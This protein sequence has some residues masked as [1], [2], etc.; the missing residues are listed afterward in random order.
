MKQAEA[1]YDYTASSAKEISF[2]AGDVFDLLNS[3]NPDWWYVRTLTSPPKEGYAPSTYIKPQ[4]ETA[5]PIRRPN[6]Q[7]EQRANN[8]ST[9]P[10]LKTSFEDEHEVE[11]EDEE[12]DD[13]EEHGGAE[14]HEE[15]RK[16]R[17]SR[18]ESG[19]K[20]SKADYDDQTYS[21]K[22][23]MPAEE[24]AYS[25]KYIKIA[26]RKIPMPCTIGFSVIDA[27]HV[28]EQIQMQG[29]NVVGRHVRIALFDKQSVLSN[30]HTIPAA[31]SPESD[32]LWR[33]SSKASVL[34]PKD[35]E[36]TCFVRTKDIDLKV[37]LLFELCALVEVNG[38][39]G[40]EI[41]DV[42]V[43][44]GILPLFTAD[45]GPI[46]N[47]SYDLKLYHG[48]PFDKQTM[49]I[50]QNR[51]GFLSN[52]INPKKSPKITLR[53]WKLAKSVHDQI[54]Q[55][56]D[57]IL[58]F[59]SAVPVLTVYRQILADVVVRHGVIGPCYEPVLSIFPTLASQNDL[60]HLLVLIWE[61]KVRNMSQKALRKMSMIKSKF[62]ECVLVIYPILQT[63]DFPR[64][65]P[66]HEKILLVWT[67]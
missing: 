49:I 35:D 27:R 36:N 54:N 56:P 6:T 65:I 16:Q 44:W 24:E 55:L 33:F 26:L 38:P 11:H 21:S 29:L 66:G 15:P 30:I 4:T 41:V 52:L 5:S 25:S 58:S 18:A 50:E 60:L 2:K 43:G 46:E 67:L 31:K 17:P 7:S 13:H 3:N 20:S 48:T 64:Y 19:R 62:T 59:L 12:E 53:V 1:L 40:A 10:R 9:T 47:K 32:S 37:S 28:E 39:D 22:G 63:H 8:Q 61:T 42:S 14:Y 34:F 51:T 45:G 23:K 57:T